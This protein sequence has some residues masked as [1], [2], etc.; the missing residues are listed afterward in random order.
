M[1]RPSPAPSGRTALFSLPRTRGGAEAL[2]LGQD[3]G[4]VTRPEVT[5]RSRCSCPATSSSRRRARQADA[6]AREPPG[7]Q[8]V[9]DAARW[10]RRSALAPGARAGAAGAGGH[11]GRVSDVWATLARTLQVSETERGVEGTWRARIRCPS[12]LRDT[13]HTA[14]R[15]CERSS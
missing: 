5:S 14:G 11:S 1:C 12:A 7:L 13:G 3:S 8:G 2:L 15:H 4:S 9:A 6:R 10:A